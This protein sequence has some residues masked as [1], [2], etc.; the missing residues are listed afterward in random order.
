MKTIV[1]A[2]AFAALTFWIA[3]KV[4]DRH[5]RNAV[6]KGT[7]GDGLFVSLIS[8]VLISGLITEYIGVYSVFGGFIAGAALPKV[9]GFSGLLQQRM[10]QVVRCF[11]LPL[12]FAYAGL[13]TYI[14][15]AFG[16]SNL[17]P[18]VG[19][20]V[21]AV[22]SKAFPA[23]IVLKFYGWRWGETIAMAGLLNARGLMVL[24]S[25]TVGL[26][27]GLIETE[28]FSVMVLIAISTT[29]MALPIY[30]LYFTKS[31]E[32]LARGDWLDMGERVGFEPLSPREIV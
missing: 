26:S 21:A 22:V 29:A 14:W 16:G 15:Q 10:H 5:L 7:I 25:A 3:P 18:A 2:A 30:R 20:L 4:L 12:F 23:V 8:F 19:L 32:A 27:L 11:F 13:N 1:P 24:I 9:Q 17:G 31:R 28:I 6:K